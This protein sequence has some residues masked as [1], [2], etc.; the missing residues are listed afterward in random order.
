MNLGKNFITSRSEMNQH[1]MNNNHSHIECP[2]NIY[3][4]NCCIFNNCLGCQCLCHQFKS[5]KKR[6]NISTDFSNNNSPTKTLLSDISNSI[7]IRDNPNNKNDNFCNISQSIINEENN[8]RI[9][10][11][12]LTKKL[13]QGSL[14]RS[15][16]N[17]NEKNYGQSR[18]FSEVNIIK[19]TI[20][21]EDSNN[22]NNRG[23]YNKSYMNDNYKNHKKY[24]DSYYNTS[25]EK[26]NILKTNLYNEKEYNNNIKR[27]RAEEKGPLRRN[28]SFLNYE[29]YYK[30]TID[31]NQINLKDVDGK[32]R[33]ENLLDNYFQKRNKHKSYVNSSKKI[34]KIKD[35]L[36]KIK[37]RK[38]NYIDLNKNNN[39]ANPYLQ[40][41]NSNKKTKYGTLIQEESNILKNNN[42]I[43]KDF[44]NYTNRN[45]KNNKYIN[46]S[47]DNLKYLEI[48]EY[49]KQKK[50]YNNKLSTNKKN[51]NKNLYENKN[52]NNKIG[53]NTNLNDDLDY[54]N[55]DF[56]KNEMFINDK[57]YNKDNNLR[58]HSFY[59]SINCFNNMKYISIISK[60]ELNKM[61][62]ELNKKN[63]E[64]S[65]YKDKIQSLINELQFYKNEIKNLKANKSK[66]KN[67]NENHY[68]YRKKSKDDIKTNI[69]NNNGNEK[70]KDYLNKK[71]N[72]FDYNKINK[73]TK[74]EN[75]NKNHKNENNNKNHKN[76]KLIGLVNKLN[77]KTDL[78]LTKDKDYMSSYIENKNISDKC[79][80]AI[81]SLT[82]SKS[83]LCFDYIN[84]KFSFRDYADFGEFQENY[85]LSFENGNEYSK[86]NSIF[87]VINNNY[88][89]ITGENC[90]MLYV[91]NSLERTMNKL[92]SLKNNHSNGALIN[93]SDNLIC[94]SG[95]YNKK[96]ELFNQSKNIWTDLPELQVERRSFSTCLIKNKYLFCLFGYNFP[97]K[98]N[99]N[100]IEYLD[101]ENYNNSSWKYLYYK[102]ENLLSLYIS[103]AIGINYNDEKI[104]I[105]G[106][107]NGKENIP[108]EYFYQIIL[109]ETFEIDKES[110]VEKIK[111]K[112]K[113]IDKNQCY[114]F[115]KGYNIFK[116]NN[117]LFY[118][119]FDDYLRAHLIQVNNMAHDVFYFD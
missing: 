87:L 14:N 57:K 44:I 6:N 59:F 24:K 71:I 20:G 67:G 74:N 30:N 34:D 97:S 114:I 53:S 15:H 10:K 76:D 113:D 102:N 61:N 37:Q 22:L 108:N 93:Y 95:N 78:S 89:I 38:D 80:Y 9:K 104:I 82:K 21:N 2:Y 36:D 40:F 41:H 60:D 66:K 99:L 29:K 48:L 101:I 91:Y 64:I 5:N 28:C 16:E 47:S 77:L 50:N 109:S 92:C 27:D 88:F 63:Q 8:N 39:L 3:S 54:S 79:I 96:V 31:L 117:N 110:Y 23:Y 90:D 62:Y 45:G 94:I 52:K 55:K 83:I 81:S 4:C 73:N 86:N 106:G 18:S 85:L 105:V 7:Y 56:K 115:N 13:F 70:D 25:N 72:N 43:N 69:S 1:Y 103:S 42:N 112:I 46:N 116:N 75:N 33:N 26:D 17:K 32:E 111:R 11:N 19:K 58:I 118:M 98:Q 100:T 107:N 35:N 84:K 119:A 12:I 49:I 65:E 51:I 68:I